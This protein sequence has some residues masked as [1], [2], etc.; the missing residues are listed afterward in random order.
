MQD[1]G[2]G[3][4]IGIMADWRALVWFKG[5]T[6]IWQLL[7]IVAKWEPRTHFTRSSIRS[8]CYHFQLPLA[9]GAHSFLLHSRL[10]VPQELTLPCLLCPHTITAPGQWL[11]GL[12]EKYANALP[13]RWDNFKTDVLHCCPEFPKRSSSNFLDNLLIPSLPCPTS[14][15]PNW[16]FLG[17]SFK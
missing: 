15:L 16:S 9:F 11:M 17:S 10:D 4:W 6:A 5:A 14:P 12:V 7:L 13:L 1:S 2:W 8:K 3:G